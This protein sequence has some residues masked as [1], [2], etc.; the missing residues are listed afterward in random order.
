MFIGI[1][2]CGRIGKCILIQLINDP[3][4]QVQVKAINIPGFDI[5]NIEQYLMYD[6]THTYSRENWN[7]KIIDK[8]SFSINGRVIYLLNNR[9]ATQLN[10]RSFDINYVIDRYNI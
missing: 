9:D 5:N 10:W 1:N 4:S 8:S 7:I 2:G 6:S 3:K